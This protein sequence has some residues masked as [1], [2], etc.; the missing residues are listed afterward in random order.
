L[1]GREKQGPEAA[2]A[3]LFEGKTCV[4]TP[5]VR[6]SSD[7]VAKVTAFWEEIGMRV[8][9]L[10]PEEHDQIL[11]CTSHLPHLAAS[12]LAGVLTPHQRNFTGS[13]FRDSTRIASGSPN[14]WVEIVRQNRSAVLAGLELYMNRLAEMRGALEREDFARVEEL[15]IDG[16]RNRDALGG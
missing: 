1:A 8:F 2:L 5:S 3:D 12:V 9:S 10:S 6:T 14:L 7:A 4:V 11:A 13:G 15:L 16:K